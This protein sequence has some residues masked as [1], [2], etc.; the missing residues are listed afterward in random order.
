MPSY[1][2]A[3]QNVQ[4]VLCRGRNHCT[5]S[6]N[7]G[8]AGFIQKRVILWGNHAAHHN[9]DVVMAKPTQCID[10]LGHER[11]VPRSQRRNADD[12][13]VAF[14]RKTSHLA[15]SLEERTDVHIK[16]NIGQGRRD[17]LGAAIVTVLSHLGNKNAG[18]APLFMLEFD[19]H[20][21]RFSEFFTIGSA[22]RVD[23]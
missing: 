7:S 9:G 11:F 16:P 10:Q 2:A 21:S 18:P 12:V 23:A 17:H 6:I 1:A 14:N 4:D 5:G 20:L 3:A 22:S 19:D 15:R 8:D 13:H